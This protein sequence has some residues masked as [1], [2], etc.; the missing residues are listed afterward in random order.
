MIGQ[1]EVRLIRPAAEHRSEFLAMVEEYREAG[2]LYHHADRQR[3]ADDFTGYVGR[4]EATSRGSGLPPGH[5]PWTT[6]WLVRDRTIVGTSR[7]RHTLTPDLEQ[8]GGHIGYDIRPSERRKG[9][10]TLILTLTLD[11]AKELGLK[12]ALLTCDRDNVA[13]ARVIERN[14]G[15]LAGVG[16]SPETGRP[17]SRYWIE[18]QSTQ[19]ALSEAKG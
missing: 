6:L 1:D 14:G 10:G 7:L 11:K 2:E 18:L 19:P 16:P 15:Q 8:E 12:R 9:Y 13:S 3:L 5:V 4:L 17:V